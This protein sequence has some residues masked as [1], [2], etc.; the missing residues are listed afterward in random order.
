MCALLK[1]VWHVLD[2]EKQNQS[3]N[4]PKRSDFE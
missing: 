4:V 1:F 3:P 2:F